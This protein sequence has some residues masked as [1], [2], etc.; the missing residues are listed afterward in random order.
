LARKLP[1]HVGAAAVKSIFSMAQLQR[2]SRS[3]AE[4]KPKSGFY[5]SRE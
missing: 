2:F 5:S 1:S 3:I 4:R